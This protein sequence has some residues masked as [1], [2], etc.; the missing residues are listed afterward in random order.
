MSLLTE[1]IESHQ[2]TSEAALD[3][4][5]TVAQDAALTA[6]MNTWNEFY[7]GRNWT[8]LQCKYLP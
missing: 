7:I 5:I 3:Q 1:L 6:S 2:M 8:F 4:S